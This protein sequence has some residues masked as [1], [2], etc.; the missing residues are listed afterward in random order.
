MQGSE[1]CGFSMN[2]DS[3]AT[4]DGCNGYFFTAIWEIISEDVVKAVQ[5]FFVGADLPILF[6]ATFVSLI[7]KV[8]LPSSFFDFRPISLCNV[9][10]RIIAKL[11]A[12][13]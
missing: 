1:I 12:V 11:L 7:P 2:G 5:D 4:P 9:V 10:Y 6:T 8:A 13:R 3:A